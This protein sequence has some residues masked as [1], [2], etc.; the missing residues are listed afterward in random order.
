ML[1]I[2]QVTDVNTK[3]TRYGN[4]ANKKDRVTKRRKNPNQ[5]AQ[6]VQFRARNKKKCYKC[7]HYEG[8]WT[9][10]VIRGRTVYHFLCKECG[11][12]HTDLS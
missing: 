4:Y 6:Y 9:Q 1:E 5:V 12:T 2:I 3:H 11:Q 8:Q 10:V 7:G